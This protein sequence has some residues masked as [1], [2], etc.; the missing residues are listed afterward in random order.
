MLP[1]NNPLPHHYPRRRSC[2]EH[3]DS[4]GPRGGSQR[5]GSPNPPGTQIALDETH[6]LGPVIRESTTARKTAVRQGGA[7]EGRCCGSGSFVAAAD[8][9]QVKVRV[10]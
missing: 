7:P 4:G 9:S 1:W 8:W 3:P 5:E 2:P 10:I 6:R